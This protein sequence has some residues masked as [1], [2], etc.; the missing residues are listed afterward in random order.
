MNYRPYLIGLL[1]GVSLISAGT[2]LFNAL[3]D[4]LDTYRWIVRE[5]F[6]LNKRDY[7][8]FA[9]IAKPIQIEQHRYERLALGSS[10]V[11]LALPVEYGRWAQDYPHGFNAGLTAASLQTVV[12]MLEHASAVSTV[13]D[14]LIGLDL[15]MFNGLT[16]ADYLHPNMLAGY[17]PNRWQ[18]RFDQTTMALFSR[19]ITH[20]SLRTLR[21]Q[22]PGLVKRKPT[23]QAVIERE[24]ESALKDGYEALFLRYED[25]F[26]RHTWTPCHDNRFA[27]YYGQG[28]DTAAIFQQLLTLA[29]QK[30]FRLTFFI[31]PMHARLLN[32]L[33]AS[34]LWPDYE[35]WKRDLVAWIEADGNPQVTLWDFSG[36][37]AY[38]REALPREPGVA[39]HW[40][41]DSS[42][43]SE[44]LA[45]IMLDAMYGQHTDFG[46]RLDSAMLET[47][48]YAQRLERT[49]WQH[50]NPEEQARIQ[51]RVAGLLDEKARNGMRCPTPDT[52]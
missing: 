21:Q 19:G 1:L 39:M 7:L 41:I 9:R 28:H 4:P 18:R 30:G 27:Y 37:H 33:D 35:Q 10:R 16:Q 12:D 51:T 2:V 42:H 14:V 5:G 45:K 32:T 24:I 15:F 3:V 25:G 20:A 48:L 29:R 38:A 40:Y 44:A 17:N 50:A 34:G 49:A 31:D 43:Y 8:S 11:D 23:G 47:H 6:N 22:Q 52:R 36:F 26:V 46:S 13:R